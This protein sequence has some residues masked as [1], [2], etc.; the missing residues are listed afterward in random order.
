MT[1]HRLH[2]SGVP[3]GAAQTP[4]DIDL[5]YATHGEL[6]PDG[7]NCV[8]L[9]TYYTGT[10]DS[11]LPWIGPGQ[12]FDTERWYVVVPDMIGNGLST[13]RHPGTGEPWDPRTDPVVRVRDNVSVQR[14]LLE[15]LGIRHVALVAGWS[16]GGLHAYQ[17]GVSYPEL[18]DA[19]LPVCASSRCWP[20]NEMFLAGLAP[21][22]EHALDHPEAS[23]FALAGFGRAYAG[24]AYSAAYF[25]DELW[26]G[27]GYSSLGHLRESWATDHLTWDPADLLMMLRTWEYADPAGP[28]GSWSQALGT[29]AARAILMPSTSDMYFT[30]A[31]NE[32]EAAQLRS[33]E[34]RPIVSDHGHIAGRPGHLP[35]VTE[36]IARAVRDLLSGRS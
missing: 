25:R 7:R 29:I 33:C 30:V 19:I 2:L 9:P 12:V 22:L 28:N 6:A 21:Y 34:L 18:V 8:V 27:D 16:M 13:I 23:D 36:Q 15:R 26:R 14:S 11:Y 20:M 17:W 35:D 4:A 5:A 1:G 3:I 31:E 32:R 24:W 10:H